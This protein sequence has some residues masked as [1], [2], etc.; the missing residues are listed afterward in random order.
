MTVLLV[1]GCV[2]V[3]LIIGGIISAGTCAIVGDDE[4]AVGIT[5]AWPIFLVIVICAVVVW[6]AKFIGDKIFDFIRQCL[7]LTT[8]AQEEE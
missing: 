5:I 7:D 1:I 6:G 4:I 8:N 2:I 3:Y